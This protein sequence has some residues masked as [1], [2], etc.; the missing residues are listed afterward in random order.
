V[1]A[2]IKTI[3]A[4]SAHAQWKTVAGALRERAPKLAQL[5][6]ETH[7]NVLTY[8]AFPPRTGPRL[9]SSNPLERN[10]EIKRRSNLVGIFP[11]DRAVIRL[12]GALRL[13]QNDEWSVSRDYMSLESLRSVTD[14]P[15]VTLPC[16]AA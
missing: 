13:E 9:L 5:M 3:F 1:M 8:M 12:T 14:D 15:L 4:Q 10:G 2:V 11:N 6:D 16:V 7:D